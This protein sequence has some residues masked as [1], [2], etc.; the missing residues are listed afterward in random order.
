MFFFWLKNHVW[1]TLSCIKSFPGMMYKIP[2]VRNRSYIPAARLSLILL[3][4]SLSSPQLRFLCSKFVFLS[5]FLFFSR[6]LCHHI[7]FLRFLQFMGRVSKN[8]KSQVILVSAVFKWYT[9]LISI[10]FGKGTLIR[11]F[12]TQTKNLLVELRRGADPA[13]LYWWVIV[14]R[15]IEYF[16]KMFLV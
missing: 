14:E 6:F 8:T 11:V 5:M 3:S 15:L 2:R 1:L 16:C 9:T 13:T 4:V 7:Q 10:L 12:D